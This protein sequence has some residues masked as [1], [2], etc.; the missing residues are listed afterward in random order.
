MHPEKSA[1]HKIDGNSRKKD[2][3]QQLGKNRS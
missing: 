1:N 2:D 3:N